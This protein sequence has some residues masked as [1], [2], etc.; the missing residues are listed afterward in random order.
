VQA[1]GVD[2]ATFKTMLGWLP[3]PGLQAPT[4]R[5]LVEWGMC[6]LRVV[7]GLSP[8][9]AKQRV[10]LKHPVVNMNVVKV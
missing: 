1:W 5:S 3:M 4:G 8:Q 2:K 7:P 10:E 6:R 9:K